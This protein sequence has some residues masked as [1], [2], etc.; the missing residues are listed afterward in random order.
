MVVLSILLPPALLPTIFLLDHIGIGRST[1]G[2]ILVT[3]ATR[4]GVIVFLVTG[5]IKAMPADLEEA[6]AI[7]GASRWRV[8][9]HVILPLITP[10]LFV[11]SVLL[12]IGVWNEF[13]FAS[14]LLPGPD[15][16]TLPLALYRFSAEAVGGFVAMRWNLVFAHIVMTS[17][18]LILVYLLAQRRVL[19]GLTEGGVKG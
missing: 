15:Q 3:I 17:L 5:F 11:G 12:M 16:A 10:I 18:P 4:I 9:R 8:Y 7:D 14:F 6:A 1:I 19:A 13:F 2:Y